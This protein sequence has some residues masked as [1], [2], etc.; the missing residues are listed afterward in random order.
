M[1]RIIRP[2]HFLSSVQKQM[3]KQFTY[4][5]KFLM[6]LVQPG[7]NDENS[8]ICNANSISCSVTFIFKSKVPKAQ[9]F[10]TGGPQTV[11]GWRL[12]LCKDIKVNLYYATVQIGR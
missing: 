4:D 3:G 9:Y 8:P 5:G 10:P 6:I 7:T 12:N 2:C 1:G 11:T